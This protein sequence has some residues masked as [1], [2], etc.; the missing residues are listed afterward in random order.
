MI[1]I[2]FFEIRGYKKNMRGWSPECP[3]TR[4]VYTKPVWLSLFCWTQKKNCGNQTVDGSHWLSIFF[5]TMDT[6][7]PINC[8][9]T[10]ILQK[11]RL[12][13]STEQRNRTNMPRPMY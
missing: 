11:Y 7:G 3:T 13:C 9:V 2:Y 8:L 6:N 4:L 5:H 12:M 1:N 10:N